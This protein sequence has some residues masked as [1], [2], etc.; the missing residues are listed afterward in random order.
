MEKKYTDKEITN[1][2]TIYSV[3][4]KGNKEASIKYLNGIGSIC[5]TEDPNQ[6]RDFYKQRIRDLLN[7]IK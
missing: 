1:I 6:R 2:L 4:S 3:L 7:A 5:K